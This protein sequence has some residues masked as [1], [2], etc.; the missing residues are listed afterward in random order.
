MKKIILPALALAMAF[1]VNAQDIP[2]RKA[3]RPGMM[4]R[5]RHHGADA[6]KSLNL[7]EDQK[8]KI[9]TYNET[10]RMKMEEAKKNENITVK[11]WKANMENLRKQHKENVQKV[12]TTDQK[13]QLEKMKT[14]GKTRMQDM[15][16]NRGE[17]MK[18][19]LGLSADQ[20]GKMDANRKA[21]VT[22]M[23]AIRENSSL[24][25]EQKTERMKELHKKQKET[26]KSIL[27]PEQLEK[28]KQGHRG[29][30]DGMR[31]KQE[32]NKSI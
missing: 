8:A 9:K 32:P 21:M 25:Q 29:G 24:S 7:N 13:S 12:L 17:R 27:T 6:F 31:K 1:G 15:Q 16:K 11:E 5:K 18:T 4:E 3:D 30:R 19:E 14:D 10:F 28:M 23:K 2:E 20:S 26:L 22:E